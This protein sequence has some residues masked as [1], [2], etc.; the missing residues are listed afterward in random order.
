MLGIMYLRGEVGPKPDQAR[1]ETLL[2]GACSAN[3]ALGCGGLGSLYGVRK[4]FK[5]ARPLFEKACGMGDALSCESLGG[6]EQGAADNKLPADAPATAR[7]ASQYYRRAC[8]L[9][10]GTGCLWVAAFIADKM[11]P[12]TAKEALDLYL[13]ACNL[14]MGMACR[15]A[16]EL[17]S[18]ETPEWRELAATLDAARL[19][20]EL[21]KQGCRLG[22]AKACGKSP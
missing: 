20:A 14:G 3:V 12:G 19:S 18:K 8:D 5:R 15:H 6:I 4:N 9:G 21:F 7:R 22:D 11:V 13:K 2:R 17:L 10:S 16:A 1:A